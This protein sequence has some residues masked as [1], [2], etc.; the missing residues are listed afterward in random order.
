MGSERVPAVV[1]GSYLAV[2][3][4]VY[5][6][7]IDLDP[8]QGFTQGSAI[9][10]RSRLHRSPLCHWL[11]GFLQGDPVAPMVAGTVGVLCCWIGEVDSRASH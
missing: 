9:Q 5:T 1:P 7:G 10:G 8:P 2:F 4:P 6:L 11:P 3:K